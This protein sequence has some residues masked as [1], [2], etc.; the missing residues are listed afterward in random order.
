MSSSCRTWG[1]GMPRLLWGLHPSA[2]LLHDLRAEWDGWTW[3]SLDQ[4]PGTRRNAAPCWAYLLDLGHVPD[5]CLIVDQWQQLLQL[6]QVSQETLPDF[7]ENHKG[8]H[9]WGAWVAQSVKR[10][11][12]ARVM[13]LQFVSLS[14]A[15]GSVLTAQSLEPASDSVSPS[16]S[17]P[18]L[19]T[20]CLSKINKHRKKILIG[21]M[22]M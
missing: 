15:L 22:L 18:P 19:L 3:Q 16:F 6:A 11:P 8:T 20:L 9:A 21:H 10:P 5:E 12:S 1:H 13:I 2:C 14:L 4:I 7:L 17:V